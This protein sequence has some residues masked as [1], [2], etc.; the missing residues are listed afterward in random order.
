M[1]FKKLQSLVQLD[2][3]DYSELGCLPYS[4]VDLSQL[5]TFQLIDWNKLENLLKEFERPKNL[6]ELNLSNFSKLRC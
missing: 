1:E 4:I 6:V 3:F 2:L 5:K